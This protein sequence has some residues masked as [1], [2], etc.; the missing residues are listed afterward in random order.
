MLREI[1]HFIRHTPASLK[2]MRTL[3]HVELYDTLMLRAAE[4]GLREQ[5]AWLCEGLGSAAP[6]SA[7]PGSETEVLEIGCG[8]GL[9]FAHYHATTRVTA[10]EPDASFRAKAFE[11]AQDAAA[12]VHVDPHGAE[13]MPYEDD[14]FDS[15][16]IAMVLCSVGSTEAV[17]KEVARV[18]KPGARVRMVEHVR[19]ENAL[20]GVLMDVVNPLWLLLNRQGCNMNRQVRPALA[21][22]GY[23][24]SEHANLELMCPGIPAFPFERIEA[25]TPSR[26]K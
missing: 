7:P 20:P 15:A 8:T 26:G 11:R 13:D 23:R 9:M 1:A 10:I 14:R 6:G 25:R 22:A 2:L 24:I 3:E 19:S 12:H 4:H 18:L 17:L 16:V 5:R 21:K